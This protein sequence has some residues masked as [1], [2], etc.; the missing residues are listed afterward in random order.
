MP[1]LHNASDYAAGGHTV[2]RHMFIVSFP[3]LH[4]RDCGDLQHFP[5]VH[6]MH[7]PGPIQAWALPIKA[8]CIHAA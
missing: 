7:A 3:R 6:G 1:V 8:Q 5:D 2:E 4:A